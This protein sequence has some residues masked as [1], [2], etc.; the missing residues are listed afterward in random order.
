MTHS[1]V[2]LSVKPVTVAGMIA[3]IDAS[4]FES[5]VLQSPRLVMVDFFTSHCG[6]CNA[7]LP[8]L[9]EVAAE[10]STTLKI[11]KFN[12][13]K[14]GDFAAQFRIHAVPTFILF[15]AGGPVGQRGGRSSKREMLAWIDEA[16]AAP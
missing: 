10:C 8:I 16:L 6:A 14:E 3:E 5:E 7:M 12:A 9:E 1:P 11:V 2:A 15:R 4:Q 13:E